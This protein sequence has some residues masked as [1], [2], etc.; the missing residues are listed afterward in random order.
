MAILNAKRTKVTAQPVTHGGT[1][2][3]RTSMEEQL[4]RSVMACMLWENEF[5]EDGQTIA[6]RI[7]SLV[8]KVSAEFAASLAVKART[9][10]KLRHVPLLIVREMARASA[11]HKTLVG[12]TLTQVIQR[13]DELTEFLAIYWKDGAN[14]PLSKQV[15]LGL[16]KAIAKFDE[17]QL[18]KYNRDGAVKLRDVLFLVH[19]KPETEG[20]AQKA[21]AV[22]TKSYQRGEVKRHVKGQAGLWRRLV[23]K[24]LATPDTWE[25]ELSA[26][27]GE[28]EGKKESWTRLLKEDKLGALALIRNLRNM[29]QAGVS[30]TLIRDAVKGMNPERVLPFRFVMAAKAAPRFEDVLEQAMFRC[31][32][33]YD[34]LSGKTVLIVDTSGSMYGYGNVS[35]KSDM[36]R[37]EAAGALTALL[38]EVS[39]EPVIYCTAG[40]D[41]SRQHK[42][43]LVPPRRGFALANV[44]TRNEMQAQIG[45]GGI[46]LTQ[47]MDYVYNQEK[48]ADRVIVLTDE[49]DTSGIGRSYNPKNANAFGK[50]NYLI[51]VASAKNGIGYG[52][53]VH[54]DGW[55]EAVIDYIMAYES[56]SNQ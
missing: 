21:K 35:A 6:N 50:H 39:E 11:K 23:D 22:K 44:I 1:P 36:T 34:K 47:V 3:V 38:R 48:K 32:E 14:Q 25:V 16:A 17:Y 29:E 9:E 27:E 43:A 4:E 30:T 55:S 54:I 26:G 20:R 56:G 8:P 10:Q 49:Q 31:L 42:T 12:D 24:E 33:K 19:A 53:F 45:G 28:G 51:N 41:S 37:V 40:N 13:A 18:A 2:A 7:V 5:Y 52:N 46:F 15:K